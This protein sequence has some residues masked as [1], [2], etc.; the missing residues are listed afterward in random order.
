MATLTYTA[1]GGLAAPPPRKVYALADPLAHAARDLAEAAHAIL[2]KYG[3]SKWEMRHA[4]TDY[5]GGAPARDGQPVRAVADSG[6]GSSTSNAMEMLCFINTDNPA[7]GAIRPPVLR[8][9]EGRKAIDLSA[10][11]SWGLWCKKRAPTQGVQPNPRN[12]VPY[13]LEGES[14]AMAAIRVPDATAGGVVFQA[15]RA[16]ARQASELMLE[17]GL[18]QARWTEGGGRQLVL[19]AAERLAPATPAVL[20]L[21]SAPGA[22]SLR[23]DGKGVARG[24][25][26]FAPA[27]FD[28]LLIGWGFVD[29][30]PR[31]SLRGQ[32]FGAI[33]GQGPPE[34]GGAG[35]AGALPALA[36]RVGAG[37]R[38]ALR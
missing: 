18:P 23:V 30:Y 15:S 1:A 25:A 11:G 6:F 13:D 32:V 17:G 2:A 16:E 33:T 21:T 29:H 12:R 27:V 35:R 8:E 4:Y 10:P 3:A 20:T 38:A 28:Q 31:D 37:A 26:R 34:R 7:A 36:G 5:V 24:D 19:R 14:F 9:L 22:Q